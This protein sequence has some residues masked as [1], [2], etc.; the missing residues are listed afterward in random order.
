MKLSS[1]DPEGVRS[2]RKKKTEAEAVVVMIGHAV[3]G[4][5][6]GAVQGAVQGAVYSTMRLEGWDGAAAPEGEG[7]FWQVSEMSRS[8]SRRKGLK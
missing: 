6:W 7:V 3:Q 8:E 4:A 5:V 2:A 1:G